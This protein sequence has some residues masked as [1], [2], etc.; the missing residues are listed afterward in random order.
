[1]SRIATTLGGALAL[2][3]VIRAVSVAERLA[4]GSGRGAG[5]V[6]LEAIGWFGLVLVIGGLAV[7]LSRRSEDTDDRL[8]PGVVRIGV[9]L[10]L[11][12]V[13]LTWALVVFAAYLVALAPP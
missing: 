3:S 8:S 9:F 13:L 2:A 10:A 1:M 12:A 7:A 6:W 11:F 4:S 5:S